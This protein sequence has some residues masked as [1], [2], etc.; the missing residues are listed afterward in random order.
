M[1]AP[2]FWDDQRKAQEV[3][4]AA[5]VLKDKVNTFYTL[6]GE[7]EDLAVAFELLQEEAERITK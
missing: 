7:V 4:N 3:I 5:N 2:G 1:Q 6:D